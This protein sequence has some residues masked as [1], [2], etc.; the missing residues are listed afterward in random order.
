MLRV[1]GNFFLKPSRG[2]LFKLITSRQAVKLLVS[3]CSRC[4]KWTYRGSQVI[5][6]LGTELKPKETTY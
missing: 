6:K 2:G 5:T 4:W 1:T 3:S